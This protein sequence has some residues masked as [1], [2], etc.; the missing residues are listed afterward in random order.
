MK[1]ITIAGQPCV[2]IDNAEEFMAWAQKN[3]V[4]A[5]GGPTELP[6]LVWTIR[7]MVGFGEWQHVAQYEYPSKVRAMAEV[8]GMEVRERDETTKENTL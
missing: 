6:C 4:L 2:R 8:L 7:E 5:N 3:N 1:E